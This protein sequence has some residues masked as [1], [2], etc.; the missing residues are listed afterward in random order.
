MFRQD[1]HHSLFRTIAQYP[2]WQSNRSQFLRMLYGGSIVCFISGTT[3]LV[4]R[5]NI[6][7]HSMFV[8]GFDNGSLTYDSLAAGTMVLTQARVGDVS[9]A[10]DYVNATNYTYTKTATLRILNPN[11]DIVFKIGK[12][13]R[14]LTEQHLYYDDYRWKYGTLMHLDHLQS[15]TYTDQRTLVARTVQ[16]DPPTI[17]SIGNEPMTYS[18]R[19]IYYVYPKWG[20]ATGTTTVDTF[21]SLQTNSIYYT[22][23]NTQAK[24][25][26]SDM[27]RLAQLTPSPF[28]SLFTSGSVDGFLLNVNSTTGKEKL[29]LYSSLTLYL[30]EPQLHFLQRNEA[31]NHYI[32]SATETSQTEWPTLQSLNKPLYMEIVALQI[33]KSTRHLKWYTVKIYNAVSP[34]APFNLDSAKGYSISAY[35]Y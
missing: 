18:F 22:N 19:K 25:V 10:R 33:A 28:I 6:T 3:F 7:D 12:Q 29:T 30:I 2:Q 14:S 11:T 15:V 5:N 4:D 20:D 32:V 17:P 8:K 13:G 21:T 34:R 9:S 24:W 27:R 23:S 26:G 31:L 16:F 1:V 35:E